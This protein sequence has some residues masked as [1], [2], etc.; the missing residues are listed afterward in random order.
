[1]SPEETTPTATPD[2]LSS[3]QPD[4]RDRR[5]FL[6]TAG[7][8]GAG[9][10]GATWA[11]PSMLALERAYAVGT[12]PSGVITFPW[13]SAKDNTQVKTGVVGT[14]TT[15]GID[16][17]IT[18]TAFNGVPNNGNVFNNWKV[19][20]SA[21]GV[22]TCNGNPDYP[23]GGT[24]GTPA[25]P[26]YPTLYSLEMAGTA[27]GCQD[28][29]T[30]ARSVA[31]TFGFFDHLTAPPHPVR[32]LSFTL[33]DV[34]TID[35]YYKDQARIFLNTTVTTGTPA[36]TGTAASNFPTVSIPAGSS[37]TQPT[38]GQAIFNGGANAAGTSNA[39]NVTLTSNANLD[40]TSFTLL[41][42]DV[43][44]SAPQSIQW[45]GISNFT[46]CKKP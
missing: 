8:V 26:V 18:H 38:A 33:L 15:G 41:F 37:V 5:A 35:D 43:L 22:E 39:G 2:L 14:S 36:S 7:V 6:K 21:A 28:A 1:V 24:T 11:A 19:R 42:T 31:V 12:C 20:T 3:G 13:P 27:T 29:G 45:I 44:G 16:V 30:A 32:S 10:A 40:I 23:M 25:V 9:V 17:Q 34:D 46:F 4:R